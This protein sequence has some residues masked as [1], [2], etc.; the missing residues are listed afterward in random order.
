MDEIASSNTKPTSIDK[1]TECQLMHSLILE[2]FSRSELMADDVPLSLDLEWL[3]NNF[4]EESYS[5]LTLHNALMVVNVET[6]RQDWFVSMVNQIRV[7]R[8]TNKWDAYAA[9]C[10]GKLND[11]LESLIRIT[12]PT[13]VAD[14]LV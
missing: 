4:D 13:I 1:V 12:S 3:I 11:F 5:F 2:G 14:Y 8:D 9:F 6:S 10:I 7:K